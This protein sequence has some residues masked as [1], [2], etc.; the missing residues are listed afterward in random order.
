[1]GGRYGMSF[2][3]KAI[4]EGRYED[5]VAEA[6]KAWV[7]DEDNPEPL[8]ERAEARAAQGRFGDAVADYEQAIAIDREAGVLE[9]EIVDDSYFSA[10]LAA[11]RAEPTVPAGVARLQ[12][13]ATTLPSGRHLK[14]AVDWMRR[15]RGELE[16]DFVK[17]RD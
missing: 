8:A 17:N 11:A 9:M 7:R 13:Y 16:S 14:E 5:A 12:T 4:Q 3:A 15:L 6:T 10:L 1:M 2:A